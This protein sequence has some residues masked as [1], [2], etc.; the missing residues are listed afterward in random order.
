MSGGLPNRQVSKASRGKY[1]NKVQFDSTG[2]SAR[3]K[4]R[5]AKKQAIREIRDE[6]A[7]YENHTD[8]TIAISTD[9]YK[10][11]KEKLEVLEN[12]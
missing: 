10:K 1:N 7:W 12:G 9:A 6:M 2:M 5:L 4:R 8:R 3:N 11:L